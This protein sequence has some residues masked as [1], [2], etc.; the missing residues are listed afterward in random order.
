MTGERRK[1]EIVIT[2]DVTG[3]PLYVAPKGNDR[4][5]AVVLRNRGRTRKGT[6][7]AYRLVALVD[8]LKRRY[9]CIVK[10]SAL[11]K[12]KPITF[13]ARRAGPIVLTV[14]PLSGPVASVA[15]KH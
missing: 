3:A 10:S 8:G 6:A 12:D 2:D 11:K 5:F 13:R 7:T 1:I 4:M 9:P 15:T 14:E